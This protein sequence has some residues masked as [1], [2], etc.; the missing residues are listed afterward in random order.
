MHLSQC[1]QQDS[2]TYCASDYRYVQC[3]GST[4]TNRRRLNDWCEQVPW[5]GTVTPDSS[6]RGYRCSMLSPAV[7][8]RNR[9]EA[10]PGTRVCMRSIICFGSGCW[11]RMYSE[12]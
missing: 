11:R 4:L 12:V 1:C 8:A 5:S 10:A 6:L 9:A 2:M 3:D 7:P